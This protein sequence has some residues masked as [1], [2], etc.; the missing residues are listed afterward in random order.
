MTIG[1]AAAALIAIGNAAKA[2]TPSGPKKNVIDEVAWIV[3]DNAIYKSEIEEAYSEMRSMGVSPGGD[4]YCVIPEQIAVEKLYL[5]QGKIDTIEAPISQ[6]SS[7]VDMYMNNFIRGLGSREKVEEMFRK[8]WNSI[9]DDVMEKMKTNYIKETVQDN[10][11]KNVKATPNDVK[12]YFAKLPADSIP[13]VPM[14]V[15]VQIM[16]LNPI[17]PKQEIEDVKARLRDYTDRVNKGESDFYTLAVMYSEDPGSAMK[18]GELGY[19]NRSDYVP[20]FA[21]V[22]FNL[23][24]P[25]KVSRIVETEYG[26]HI[27]QYIDRRGDQVNVRHILLKPKVSS[28]DL[29]DATMRL[30]SI[31]KEIV[32][33]SIPFDYAVRMISQDKDSRNNKGLMVNSN[34]ESERFGTTR[35]EMQDLPP[36]IARRIESMQPGDISQ[37]FVMTDQKKNQDVAVI[38]RLQT[39]VPGHSANL[40]EDY[41]MLKRMYEAAEKE[42]IIKDWVEKKIKDTYVHISDG[43]NNCD[44]HYEGWEKEKASTPQSSTHNP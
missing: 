1:L 6:L 31:R 42:R 11:T 4:P 10:L 37:P 44:F 41:T 5:H 17:I 7:R 35:F 22:A 40:A 33:G 12:K 9:R 19:A 13:Y 36:E 20:E 2:D 32:A 38:V 8:P 43:W 30:D 16:Q 28:K 21:N 23:N 15:E 26:Y 14:Q 24:D 27:I 34:Q 3:G 39:R 18:G 25:K 29:S